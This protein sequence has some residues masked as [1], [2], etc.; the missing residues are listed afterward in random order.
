MLS[1]DL[2]STEKYERKLKTYEKKN[3]N[4][5]IA[6][7]ANLDTYHHALNQLNKPLQIKAGFIHPE[8]KG[9]VAIDQKGGKQKVK[10][11]QTRLYVYPDTKSGNLY[12]LTIGDKKTQR[13]DIK[14]C[15]D[16]VSRIE[17]E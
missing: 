7:L 13:A 3:P 17:R 14:Y 4:E 8:P 5:L 1:W 16:F 11:K 9:I 2:I 15:K 12:L 6:M 10:L